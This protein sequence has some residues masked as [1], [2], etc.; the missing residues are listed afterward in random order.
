MISM[1]LDSRK[2]ENIIDYEK[3]EIV[4]LIEKAREEL[5]SA[6][7]IL[8]EDP[9]HA[10]EIVRK[11]KSTVIP[12]IKRKFVEAK[13]RLKSEILSLKGELATIS[14][15]E[16]RRKIIEE[17]EELRNSLDDF[18]DYLEDELDNLE[19]SISDLKADIK[20]IL[21]EAKKRKSIVVR[22]GKGE[23]S[24]ERTP[25][26]TVIS[27]IRLPREDAEIID[28]LV[29]AGIFKSRSE[30]VSYFT[31]KGIEANRE[32]IGNIRSKVEELKKIRENLVK[33]FKT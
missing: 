15:V 9:E 14:N 28:L 1:S 3:Q 10:L 12:E 22:A 18:E 17:M 7:S 24:I 6:Y 4:K 33:E 25:S 23:V 20:D 26:S 32:L 30:A 11:L 21:K 27:S 5:K 8:G 31:H 2:F 13:S 19:D 29:E 16:E